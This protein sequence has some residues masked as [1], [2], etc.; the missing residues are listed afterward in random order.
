MKPPL[1]L[2]MLSHLKG[3]GI[4]N[5]IQDI[6]WFLVSYE[7]V[8]KWLI[9]INFVLLEPDIEVLEIPQRYRPQDIKS[10]SNESG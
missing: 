10:L 4:I 9:G 2:E 7:N 6:F 8:L 1:V 3:F 5:L